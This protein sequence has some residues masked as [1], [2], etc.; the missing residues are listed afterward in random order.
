MGVVSSTVCAVPL[1][2]APANSS[3][4]AGAGLGNSPCALFTVPVPS[5]TG[6]DDT[7]A[8]SSDSRARHVPTMSTRASS[9]PTS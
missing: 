8:T 9:P 7:A 6:L 4:T 5:E 1:T 2:G 3:T